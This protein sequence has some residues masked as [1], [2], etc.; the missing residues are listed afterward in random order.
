V[1]IKKNAKFWTFLDFRF[2]KTENLKKTTFAKPGRDCGHN[3]H[4]P[5]SFH[6]RPARILRICSKKNSNKGAISNFQVV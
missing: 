3:R 1:K 5:G 4:I 2:V 6:T